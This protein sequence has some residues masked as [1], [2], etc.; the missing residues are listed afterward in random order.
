M[1]PVHLYGGVE[2]TQPGPFPDCLLCRI[3]GIVAAVDA[4][5]AASE[6]GRSWPSEIDAAE[7]DLRAKVKSWKVER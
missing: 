4:F 1:R 6:P 3:E 2:H 5:F 7:A